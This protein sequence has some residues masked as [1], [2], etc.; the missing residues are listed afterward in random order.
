MIKKIT[1][2]NLKSL[3]K[4]VLSENQESMKSIWYIKKTGEG[5]KNIST[6]KKDADRFLW[7]SLKGDGDVY[8]VEVPKSDWDSEKVSAANIEQYA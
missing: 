7:N 8:Y 3:I 5:V 6:S 2:N 1:L 4:Q